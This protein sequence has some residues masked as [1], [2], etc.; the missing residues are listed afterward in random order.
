MIYDVNGGMIGYNGIVISNN[1]QNQLLN[2]LGKGGQSSLSK[3]NSFGQNLVSLNQMGN[4]SSRNF[5]QEKT[6]SILNTARNGLI[7]NLA[8]HTSNQSLTG[9]NQFQYQVQLILEKLNEF[10]DVKVRLKDPL[11]ENGAHLA[12]SSRVQTERT[13]HN[14]QIN[15]QSTKQLLNCQSSG[16]LDQGFMQN[17]SR[18]NLNMISARGLQLNGLKSIQQQQT[19]RRN[20]NGLEILCETCLT[21]EYS[22]YSIQEEQNNNKEN[23]SIGINQSKIKQY[24][25]GRDI[26]ELTL[27]EKDEILTKYHMKDLEKQE[28][29]DAQHVKWQ[30]ILN[31]QKPKKEPRQLQPILYREKSESIKGSENDNNLERSQNLQNLLNDLSKIDVKTEKDYENTYGNKEKMR[32]QQYSQNKKRCSHKDDSQKSFANSVSLAD[33]ILSHKSSI[34]FTDNQHPRKQ[35]VKVPTLNL[36][37][38][39]NQQ[40]EF[41]TK[42]IQNDEQNQKSTIESRKVMILNEES[43][44][45]EINTSLMQLRDEIKE[46]YP[47]KAA[48]DFINV[49]NN[50]ADVSLIKKDDSQL[51]QANDQTLNLND[52]LENEYQQ[53]QPKLNQRELRVQLGLVSFG[54]S[55][56]LSP[57]EKQ[58]E[59]GQ[60]NKFFSTDQTKQIQK[61]QLQIQSQFNYDQ[62]QYPVVYPVFSN[63]S[64]NPFYSE[65]L[66]PS[67]LS[68]NCVSSS[69]QASSS[70]GFFNNQIINQE[71]NQLL[72]N[73][74]NN[75]KSRQQKLEKDSSTQKLISNI[76]DL[77]SP[78]VK[79]EPLNQIDRKQNDSKSNDKKKI[80]IKK[81]DISSFTKSN[82]GSRT[83]QVQ[84]NQVSNFQD[85]QDNTASFNNFT[86]GLQN[87]NKKLKQQEQ[88]TQQ[89]QF[90]RRLQQSQNQQQ[91]IAQQIR[92]QLDNSNEEIN[93][94]E[95]SIQKQTPSPV[96]I[97]HNNRKIQSNGVRLANPRQSM[98]CKNKP[99]IAKQMNTIFSNNVNNTSSNTISSNQRNQHQGIQSVSY[100]SE[101][102]KKNYNLKY[103]N[104]GGQSQFNS[105][106]QQPQISN[107]Q[108]INDLPS[109]LQQLTEYISIQNQQSQRQLPKTTKNQSMVK[110]NSINNTL[111]LETM[112][113]SEERLPDLSQIKQD[114]NRHIIRDSFQNSVGNQQIDTIGDQRIQIASRQLRQLSQQS[115][116]NVMDTSKIDADTSLKMVQQPIIVRRPMV[117]LSK[118][119]FNKTRN[120]SQNTTNN[121]VQAQNIS[122]PMNVTDNSIKQ[123]VNQR[124]LIR[125]ISKI[126]HQD[127]AQKKFNQMNMIQNQTQQNYE[128]SNIGTNMSYQNSK[129]NLTILTSKAQNHNNFTNLNIS[130]QQPLTPLQYQPTTPANAPSSSGSFLINNLNQ[131]VNTTIINN[132][133]LKIFRKRSKASFQNSVKALNDQQHQDSSRGSHK[134]SFRQQN[135]QIQNFNMML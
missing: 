28:L 65:Q 44:F 66:K 11:N 73:T 18:S 48:S 43:I 78:G 97:R 132:A 21:N 22:M 59:T 118:F 76:D 2:S 64:E 88:L 68:Y 52:S 30:D 128:Q 110:L 36:D 31:F 4:Q 100:M 1:N 122:T 80:I 37:K 86:L 121:L 49:S 105:Q 72:S 54:E 99:V 32:E 6:S 104:I 15:G 50:E 108:Q 57:I 111:K 29:K 55:L 51:N 7:N 26:N 69:D 12:P 115:K 109:E 117:K 116:N 83:K 74:S 93:T 84:I 35:Q 39:K 133:R 60:K 34:N 62:Q 94:N 87:V 16:R 3:L 63:Q 82:S 81:A 10:I 89:I 33:G 75:N 98:N 124:Y 92:N 91:I 129:A 135:F 27:V 112:T 106:Q 19:N 24:L 14:K 127:D 120:D 71:I 123:N 70:Q 61:H 45:T 23:Q 126:I 101:D 46:T 119:N 8:N 96:V 20:E 41:F 102:Q 56:I 40:K 79:N 58:Q 47:Q 67:K 42:N 131:T 103:N 130:N 13:W 77:F 25:G 5:I 85:S 107:F 9:L 38:I 134:D 90:G 95:N 53:Q 17:S 114:S 113:F 125:R